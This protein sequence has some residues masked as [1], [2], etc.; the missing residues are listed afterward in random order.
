MGYKCSV[1]NC[2]TGYASEKRE[3]HTKS[4]YR[5]PYDHELR[6][7]WLRAINREDI[8]RYTDNWRVCADHFHEED[9]VYESQDS[10]I[11]RIKQRDGKTLKV[12]KLKSCAI[13]SIFKGQPSYLSP[14]LSTKRRTTSSSQ[15]RL[16]NENLRIQHYEEDSSREK[17]FMTSTIYLRS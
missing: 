2:K 3:G 6:R 7:K 15:S 5:F 17:K 14:V 4:L 13:P 8:D 9:F 12:K 1:P 11:A 16:E 10:H